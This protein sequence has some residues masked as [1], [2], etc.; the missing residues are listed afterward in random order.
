MWRAYLLAALL[1]SIP[2]ICSEPITEYRVLFSPQDHVAEE[3]ISLIDKERSCIH[4]AV[5]TFSHRGVFKAL[6]NAAERGVDVQL[7]VDPSSVKAHS[8][9]AKPGESPFTVHVWS[10]PTETKRQKNGRVIQKK[11]SL[12][13]EGF[14]IFGDKRV[15]ISS[16]PL[17]LAATTTSRGNAF[18]FEQ[19]GVATRYLAEFDR[20]KSV[21]GRPL[22]DYLTSRDE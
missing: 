20:L 14:C 11:K 10:P 21:G 9:L 17:T 22:S 16:L 19:E 3:L 12:L 4:M 5:N 18:V 8:L 2:C 1:C 7:L 6:L 15:W 13:Q